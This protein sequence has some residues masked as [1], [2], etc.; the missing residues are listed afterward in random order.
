[1]WV[2][3]APWA[4]TGYGTQT[5]IFTPRI[6]DLGHEVAI[7]AFYGLQGARLTWEQG[8]E[9]Y[10]A[11]GD[12][13]GNDAVVPHVK[14][15]GADVVITLVDAWVLGQAYRQG[16]F[17]WVAWAPVDHDPI[18]PKVVDAL[19]TALVPIAYSKFGFEKM[20]EADLDPMYVPH[21]VPKDQYLPGDRDAARSKIFTPEHKDKFIAVMVAANKGWPVRKS[22]PQ[23]LEAWG[24]FI[25]DHPNS[26]LYMH[27]DYTTRMHG[28][29][30]MHEANINGIGPE[31]IRFADP[32]TLATG[33]PT[34]FINDL[35]NAAD[36]LLNPSMGEGFGLTVLEAQ[37]AGCPVITTNATAMSE[38]TFAGTAVRGLPVSTPQLSKQFLPSVADILEALIERYNARG[39]EEEDKLRAHARLCAEEYDADLVTEKYWKPALDAVSELIGV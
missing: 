28:C 31:N 34:G 27:S 37:M 35:Y 32:T 25:R 7:L 22:F 9:V 17:P 38:L 14:H 30:L 24:Y 11:I 3:N 36:V 19:R 6:R 5:S 33:Y 15:F 12:G 26:L 20:L 39:T 10:P 29:D 16:V 1:M 13:W 2:S 4:P 18:P 21:G 8:I 23:V